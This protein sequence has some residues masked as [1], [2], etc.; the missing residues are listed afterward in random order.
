MN[1]EKRGGTGIEARMDHRFKRTRTD[2]QDSYHGDSSNRD[3]RG[4]DGDRR[5]DGGR[6]YQNDYDG[7]GGNFG[8]SSFGFGGQY[9]TS[10]N[11][12]RRD[13]R[14]Y[15]G[16]DDDRGYG[17]R[18]N[19]GGGYGG[20]N[21]GS[22]SFSRYDQDRRGGGYD[23]DRRGRGYDQDRR[24]GYDQDRRGGDYGNRSRDYNGGGGYGGRDSRGGYGGGREY[25]DRG[26]YGGRDGG[27]GGP[28][29]G[30]GG[31]GGGYGPP[32]GRYG[33]RGG[34]RGGGGGFGGRGKPAP[35]FVGPCK[36]VTNILLASPTD[37]FQFHQYTFDAKDRNNRTVESAGRRKQLLS[38]AL[39]QLL[40]DKSEKEKK[41]FLRQIF[42]SG[43]Y[44]FSSN[45]LEGLGE[46]P[47]IL[48]DGTQGD[49]DTLSI[50]GCRSFTA[51]SELVR[52]S[53]KETKET[54]SKD[55][56]SISTINIEFRC[57]N[58]TSVFK[59]KNGILSHCQKTGH[60]PVNDLNLSDYE[61][62]SKEE[63][64][65]FCNIIVQRAMSERMAR[66]G[67]HYIDPASY[68]T[69]RD[70][71]GEE[72]GVDV[73]QAYSVE[74][75]VGKPSNAEDEKLQLMLTVDLTAKLIRTRS[76]L[77]NIYGTR[78]PNTTRF[79]DQEINE[80]KRRWIGQTVISKIDK[81]C[82]AIHD[83]VF[84]ESAETLPVG[85]LNMSH[86]DYFKERKNT[87]LEY[88]RAVP[89]VAVMGRNQQLIHLPP[90]LICADELDD[91][92]KMMLPKIASF[93]PETRNDAIDKVKKF[94]I[95]G[96]QKSRDQGGLLPALGIVLKEERLKLTAEV[97]ATPEVVSPGVKI[98]TERNWAPQLARAKFNVEPKEVVTLNV[99]VIHH[100]N[101]SYER[102]YR[103]LTRMI[104]GHESTFRFP[105]QPIRVIHC[106]DDLHRHWG[107]VE[108]NF[109]VSED[110]PPNCKCFIDRCFVVHQDTLS[111]V[112]CFHM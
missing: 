70:R 64:T 86:A 82:H 18:D 59:N 76:L 24:G 14:G 69:P 67:R 104:N 43:T 58:C 96:A 22:S 71:F 83:L 35:K 79:S 44:F 19:R 93:D 52:T 33:D 39:D 41:S 29:G 45:L 97:L 20:D 49:G 51:P 57:A 102:P 54:S 99:I 107:E 56:S 60:K 12:S 7:R 40:A 6:G 112:L 37:C 105:D 80:A 50:I 66:W 63:F 11:D 65:H 47:Q 1:L 111:F 25:S 100:R 75:N 36:T 30:R 48:L 28:P 77:M 10:N 101:I 16:R 13:D 110:L 2:P 8:G 46:L 103:E 53:S 23:Q 88:P 95:P 4:R 34:G 98:N 84:E 38:I 27:Y 81:K 17:S 26:G 74:F 3:D 91:A 94:L 55:P 5:R 89:M 108:K 31:G 15:G 73:F 85:D 72:L 90:E 21:R 106:D 68:V 78:N 92:I 9:H 42:F 32:G 62:A 61:P 109:D 87:T